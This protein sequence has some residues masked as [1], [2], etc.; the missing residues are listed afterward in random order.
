MSGIM[1]RDRDSLIRAS[2]KIIDIL[3]CKNLLIT[4]GEKGMALFEGSDKLFEIPT[5]AREVYDVSG[6]GDTVIATYALAHAVHASPRVS[7]YLANVAAGIVVGK[8]GTAEVTAEELKQ[9]LLKYRLTQSDECVE[10][11]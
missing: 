8:L 10:N 3:K 11:E 2:E 7:A 4:R 1:I 9:T 6:A 5:Q